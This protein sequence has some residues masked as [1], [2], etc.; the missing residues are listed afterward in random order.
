MIQFIHPHPAGAAIT[1]LCK[2]AHSPWRLTRKA[3]AAAPATVEDGEL[4]AWGSRAG[5]QGLVIDYEGLTNGQPFSY[6]LFSEQ[7]GA[8]LAEGSPK[9]ATPGYR[10]EALYASPDFAGLVRNRLEVTLAGDLGAGKL[11]HSEGHIPVLS[12]YPQIDSVRLPVVTVILADRHAE[13]RG[14]GDVV[15][16]TLEGLEE[17]EQLGWLDRS[18]LQVTAWAPSHEHRIR[19]RDALQRALMLN[20]SIFAHAG[21]DLLDVSERDDQD[22]EQFGVPVFMSVFTVSSV[23]AAIV[24]A[25]SN[26][27]QTVEQLR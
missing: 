27:I 9:S 6:Q 3:G 14:V 19:L 15:A 4:R 5:D 12:S 21:Y 26:A 7:D 23:H 2:T 1:L 17:I 16:K 13:A 24:E 8:W 22:F 11:A 20:M 25:R 10:S 18:T